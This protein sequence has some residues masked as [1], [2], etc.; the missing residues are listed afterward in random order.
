MP[1]QLT[2][3]PCLRCGVTYDQFRSGF[4]F[5]QVRAMMVTGSADPKDWRQKRRRSVLGFWRELKISMWYSTHGGC[6]E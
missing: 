5:A 6:E 4:T 2:P 3:Q 1:S